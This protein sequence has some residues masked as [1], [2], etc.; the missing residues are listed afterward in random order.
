MRAER[1]FGAPGGNVN[2]RPQISDVRGI[3]KEERERERHA[4]KEAKLAERREAREARP[5][6]RDGKRKVDRVDIRLLDGRG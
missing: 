2:G 3:A 1:P 5:E 6:Q 4:K